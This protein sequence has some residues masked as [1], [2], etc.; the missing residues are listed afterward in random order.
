MRN[1]PHIKGDVAEA[2]G[3]QHFLEEGKMVF[4]NVSQHGEIDFVTVDEDGKIELVDVKSVSI[5]P[6][7]GY[8]INRS[9]TELQKKLNVKILYISTAD[10]GGYKKGEIF[11]NK[12]TI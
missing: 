8:I 12:K 2:L 7:D 10:E 3:Q 9:P 1:K 5:R 4:K 6:R 11:Y